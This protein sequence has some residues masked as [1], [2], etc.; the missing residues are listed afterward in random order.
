MGQIGGEREH[1]GRAGVLVGWEACC[2]AVSVGQPYGICMI[3]FG[4]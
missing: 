3:M 1:Q 4:N 2:F